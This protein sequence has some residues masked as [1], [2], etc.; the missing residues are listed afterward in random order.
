MRT[1]T[2]R[3]ILH[4]WP[5]PFPPRTG[6]APGR[7]E[8]AWPW[9]WPS[10]SRCCCWRPKWLALDWIYG[11]GLEVWAAQGDQVRID[12]AGLAHMDRVRILLIAVLV[13]AVLAGV[14]RARW[15]VVAHLLVALLA[16][17]ILAA[18]RQEWDN[19]HSTSPTCIRYS[20]NC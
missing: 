5:I 10:L 9:T 4:P 1:T 18:E 2:S 19:S 20:A 7:T 14:L 17:G 15:T 11:F 8:H 12:A 16:G 6:G 3:G 13:L